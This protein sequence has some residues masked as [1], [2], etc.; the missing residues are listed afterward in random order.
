MRASPEAYQRERLAAMLHSPESIRGAPGRRAMMKSLL[1]Q[2]NGTAGG[3]IRTQ[4]YPSRSLRRAFG[5]GL[6][7][8]QTALA[9]A[10]VAG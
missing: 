10:L 3:G 4:A 5:S 8:M 2:Y 1:P 6:Q 9:L 7:P